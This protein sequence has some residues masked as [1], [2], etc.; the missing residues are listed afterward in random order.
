MKCIF[1]DKINKVILK[2][3]EEEFTLYI[4]FMGKYIEEMKKFDKNVI[5]IGK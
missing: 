2:A 3:N 4:S 5:F 1:S